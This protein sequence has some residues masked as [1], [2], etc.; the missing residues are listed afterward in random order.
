MHYRIKD[1]LSL[2][3]NFFQHSQ[4]EFARELKEDSK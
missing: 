3:Q 4:E 2:L 1:D